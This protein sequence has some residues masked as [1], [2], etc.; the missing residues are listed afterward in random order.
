MQQQ[1]ARGGT[2]HG[3]WAAAAGAS[4]C[5]RLCRA[6]P[7]PGRCRRG[8]C[9]R[10]LTGPRCAA[11]RRAAQGGRGRRSARRTL[12][13]GR[14]SSWARSPADPRPPRQAIW[15]LVQP[16]Q[17]AGR[18][19]HR[20]CEGPGPAP[21][22]G[23][24]CR[25]AGRRQAGW[26]S[27]AAPASAVRAVRR[28]PAS[29][30]APARRPHS[31][32]GAWPASSAAAA[33]RLPGWLAVH[34]R[35]APQGGHRSGGGARKARCG[36]AAGVAGEQR[37]P[38]ADVGCEARSRSSVS[39]ES[40]QCEPAELRARR[41]PWHRPASVQLAPTGTREPHRRPAGSPALCLLHRCLRHSQFDRPRGRARGS[42]CR[43]RER[44][45]PP[46]SLPPAAAA[47]CRPPR[48]RCQP[49]RS[50]RPPHRNWAA[51]VPS[52]PSCFIHS[53]SG[54]G[55]SSCAAS[56]SSTSSRASVR[57]AAA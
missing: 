38:P 23:S 31:R 30:P 10:L 7:C 42:R 11:L 49:R 35:A 4:P 1:A 51:V 29:P 8:P 48:A 56:P 57:Y 17:A 37:S 24:Q 46:L 20:S 44:D 25:G 19:S 22:A 52:P 2:C 34:K 3:S 50:R 36:G 33:A 32:S 9:P 26:A 5:A 18:A 12:Q 54:C 6:P 28:R 16:L 53:R 40:T 15:A 21:P 41:P 47:S 55:H 13:E 39:S 14:Q 45:K 43:L 27:C